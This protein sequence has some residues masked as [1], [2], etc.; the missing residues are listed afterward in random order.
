VQV[1]E[2]RVWPPRPES[3][4]GSAL[5]FDVQRQGFGRA[6]QTTGL[7][8]TQVNNLMAVHKKFGHHQRDGGVRLGQHVMVLLSVLAAVTAVSVGISGLGCGST[9]F[10]R[11]KRGTCKT[12][13]GVGKYKCA[14]AAAVDP[15]PGLDRCRPFEAASMTQPTD[16][17]PKPPGATRSA[18]GIKVPL[19][20]AFWGKGEEGRALFYECNGRWPEDLPRKPRKP[21]KPRQPSPDGLKTAAQAVAKLNCSIKTLNAHVAA[22]D[23]R[24]VSIGKGRKRPRR[25]FADADLNEF[26]TN[27][28]RKD[29]PCLSTR[30]RGRRTGSMTSGGEVIA[31]T[32]VQRP[33]SDGKRKK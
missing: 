20:E 22:G 23:L 29:S 4:T 3:S 10:G 32:G 17:T 19:L 6:K 9:F 31:F 27:Q 28:T 15:R 30:T 26:I 21:R 8:Q 11:R 18:K 24:Y 1:L 2:S 7:S 16:I 14:P 5:A 25:M 13:A 12:P 33:G